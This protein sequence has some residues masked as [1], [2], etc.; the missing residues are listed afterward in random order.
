MEIESKQPTNTFNIL[1]LRN[2]S[3]YEIWDIAMTVNPL[4]NN[5]DHTHEILWRNLT[6][7]LLKRYQNEIVKQIRAGT[8]LSEA[9]DK[10]LRWSFPEA[11]LYSLTVITTIGE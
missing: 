1:Y 4:R 11:F 7:E 5:Y 9:Q 2:S 6:E 8:L 10:N 3:A